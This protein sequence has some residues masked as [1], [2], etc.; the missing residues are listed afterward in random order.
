VSY[1]LLPIFLTFFTYRYKTINDRSEEMSDSVLY[2][3]QDHIATITLNRPER[4]NAL[5]WEAYS[6]GTDMFKRANADNN[7]RCI[8]FTGAGR[9]FCSGDDV[10]EI[11]ASGDGL[12]GRLN[13]PKKTKPVSI[14]PP[15]AVSMLESRCPIINAVNGAAVG[16]GMELTLLCD[17]RIAS[18]RARFSEMF[19]RRGIIATSISYDLLPNIVGPARAA[20]MLL[21][22]EMIDAQQALEFG[23]VSRVIPHDN[24]MQEATS[25]AEKIAA[26]PPLAVERA[27]QA[28][29]M[30]RDYKTDELDSYLSR[31]LGDLSATKD[32]KESVAAFLEKRDAVYTGE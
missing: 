9:S 6:L 19:I 18:D 5:N 22:G 10:V 15:L 25:L 7:V 4:H 28:L 13:T 23:L 32:H 11:M 26:N 30:K 8:I 29:R 31:S 3:M 12:E 1:C 27:K 24:L 16:F 14:I 2:E 17:V 21:T 20:E